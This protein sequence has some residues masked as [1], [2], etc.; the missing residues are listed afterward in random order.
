MLASHHIM[1]GLDKMYSLIIKPV[2]IY[3]QCGARGTVMLKLAQTR[4]ILDLCFLSREV[5][6]PY[7]V[8]MFLGNRAMVPEVW[9]RL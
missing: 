7:K 3:Q 4:M 8:I 9:M 1:M 6:K 2:I 5:W